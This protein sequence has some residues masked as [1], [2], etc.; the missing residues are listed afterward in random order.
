M[1]L[2]TNLV[3][4][5]EMEGNAV[6]SVSGNNGTASNV[7]FSTTYGKINQGG[8][9]VDA[10]PSYIDLPSALNQPASLS[11][12]MWIN[13]VTLTPPNNEAD[14]YFEWNATNRNYFMF[15]NGTG[16]SVYNGNGLTSQDDFAS[17]SGALTAGAWH[18]IV[19]TRSG[20]NLVI[21]IDTNST[22]FT[23]LYSGGVAPIPAIGSNSTH[24]ANYSFGGNIDEVGIWSRALTSTEVSELY[25]GGAG[26]PYSSIAPIKDNAIMFGMNF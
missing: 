1:A 14:I 21:Y 24:T 22:S 5:F 2:S 25:N 19:L 7:L 23:S 10:T 20:T 8:N 15:Q 9:Y 17:T 12:S 4:Y 16:I 26:L 13:P 18:H 6:D 11:I 3:G